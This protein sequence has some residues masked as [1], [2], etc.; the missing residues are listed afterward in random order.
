MST[1][2]SK[3][4]T[5]ANKLHSTGMN[6][7][8]ATA[9]AWALVKAQGFRSKVT[10]VTHGNRQHALEQLSEAGS[11]SVD[12]KR[13]PNNHYDRNAIAVYAQ[14]TDRRSYFIGYL[15]ASLAYILAPLMDKGYRPQVKGFA[16]TG[17]YN[18]YVSYGACIGMA[19]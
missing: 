11:I 7:S 19:V 6:R 2:K 12:F 14:T 3:V 17:G 15:K 9:K 10:G 18:D 13:E 16:V 8:R 1:L 4:M 5:I